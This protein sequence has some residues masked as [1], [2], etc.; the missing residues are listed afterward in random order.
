[1]IE[2][3]VRTGVVGGAVAVGGGGGA[4]AVMKSGSGPGD[5]FLVLML[6][7]LVLL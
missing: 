1:M 6:L 3:T 2:L 7:R 4:A 5:Q